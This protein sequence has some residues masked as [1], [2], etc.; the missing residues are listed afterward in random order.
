M[1]NPVYANVYEQD[2]A[3]GTVY[4]INPVL[5]KLMKERG[6]YDEETMRR[7]SEAQG[8]VQGEDW[9]TQHEKDVLRTAFELNP[10]SILKMASDRQKVMGPRAQG[11]SINLYFAKEVPEEEISRIHHIA[12]EDEYIHSLYYI[13]S[14]NEDSTYKVDTSLCAGCEG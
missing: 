9:L 3:G 6:K 4:R 8:S 1:I 11:Q 5:L 2:T 7:I 12:C 13:H 10:E 14:L